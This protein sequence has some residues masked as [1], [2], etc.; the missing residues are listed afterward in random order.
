MPIQCGVLFPN[1]LFS[2]SIFDQIVSVHI[3]EKQTDIFALTDWHV[4]TV[5]KPSVN[6]DCK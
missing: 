5:F 4:H 3:Y 6:D 2:Y 1:Q